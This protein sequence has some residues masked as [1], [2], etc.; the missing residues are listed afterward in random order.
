MKKVI[1]NIVFLLTASVF[2][3]AQ[4]KYESG[5]QKAFGLW[6]SGNTNEAIAL[7]E[8]IGQAEKDNWIPLYHAA[9]AL[10]GASFQVEDVNTKNSMLEKAK[11]IV[12]NAQ[13]RS[14]NNAELITLEGLLYTAYLSID[15]ATYGMTLP[16]KIQALHEQAISI[17]PDNPRALVN[18]IEFEMGT[19]RFFGQDL[20]PFCEKMKKVI[21]KFEQETP[22][23][24]FAPSHGLER[25][26][27]IANSC[28]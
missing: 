26:Q 7:F 14:E 27:Q 12:A 6:Q 1:T 18:K 3:S 23:V 19:A 11:T 22:S 28:E 10:I 9:N 4:S 25:A 8:R 13:K 24:P 15:P 20:S 2:L 21:P 5:M 17:D 16:Q